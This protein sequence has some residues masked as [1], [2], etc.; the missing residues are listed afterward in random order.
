VTKSVLRAP[1]VALGFACLTF[2]QAGSVPTKVGI[3]NFQAAIVG[4]K[5]GQKA[6]NE[7]QTKFDPKRRELEKKQGDIA[8]LRDQVQKGSN[9]M[10]EEQ[11]NKLIREID[12]R[13]R[14]LTRETEDAQGEFDQEQQKVL[15]ELG[16]RM[17]SILQK[18]ATDN[19][20]AVILD[21][22]SPQSP[23][24]VAANGTDVTQEIVNL[25]D[26]S[27]ASAA[28]A[29]PKPATGGAAAPKPA[30]PAARKPAATK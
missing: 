19:G 23:V 17:I 27:A 1:I 10:A 26:R 20:Y 22:S 8:A 15:Q 9:T 6:A 16:Q 29:A 14:L 12:T 4:T 2:G 24:L 13:T 11:K 7:L 28:P 21:V 18:Y 25:Y 3:I 30:A 5:D